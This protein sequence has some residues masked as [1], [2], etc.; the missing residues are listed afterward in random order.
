MGDNHSLCGPHQDELA[1]LVHN[2]ALKT[3]SWNQGFELSNATM[4]PQMTVAMDVT[5]SEHQ[6]SLKPSYAVGDS[7]S[8]YGP[9][10][11]ELAYPVHHMVPETTPRNHVSGLSYATIN[12]QMTVAVD[13]TRSEG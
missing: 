5:H 3:P 10:Q 7:H 8:R 2:M 13:P 12:P 6:L 4:I 1:H 11:D 9:H